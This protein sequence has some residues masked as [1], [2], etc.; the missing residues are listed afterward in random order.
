MT[1]NLVNDF[2]LGNRGFILALLLAPLYLVAAR[3]ATSVFRL[4]IEAA[5]TDAA[6]KEAGA[7]LLRRVD[8]ASFALG[9]VGS[10]AAMMLVGFLWYLEFQPEP[11]LGMF[12]F[13][14]LPPAWRAIE[15]FAVL[16]GGLIATLVVS[17]A[18]R[19][20]AQSPRARRLL[21]VLASTRAMM[22]ALVLCIATL[23]VIKVAP[24]H[25]RWTGEYVKDFDVTKE[26]QRAFSSCWPDCTGAVAPLEVIPGYGS[27]RARIALTLVGGVACFVLVTGL[28]LRRRRREHEL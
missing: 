6:A 8:F 23:A 1:L 9:L 4:S 12:E 27:D 26:S 2:V 11:D 10:A 25:A 20:E 7:R 15:L 24:T 18:V 22:A 14:M 3:I 19:R 17:T 16:G 21:D 13:P 28:A 5:H